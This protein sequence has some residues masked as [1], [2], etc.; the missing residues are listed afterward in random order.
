MEAVVAESRRLLSALRNDETR[1]AP[2]GQSFTM[3]PAGKV[4]SPIARAD[5]QCTDPWD[6]ALQD[7]AKVGWRTELALSVDQ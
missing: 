2:Q 1:P 5:P 4:A 3:E 6:P 7:I